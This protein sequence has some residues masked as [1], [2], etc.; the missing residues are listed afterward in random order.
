MTG[1]A[2]DRNNIANGIL[3]GIVLGCG[4][5]FSALAAVIIKKIISLE[6]LPSDE[7]S[8]TT[9]STLPVWAL[10]FAYIVPGLMGLVATFVK[11]KGMYITH[12]VFSIITLLAMGI[13]FVLGIISIAALAELNVNVPQC[14]P[15]DTG[16]DIPSSLYSMCISVIVFIILG[17][18]FTLVT[19]ILSGILACRNENNAHLV[20]MQNVPPSMTTVAVTSAASCYSNPN[21]P[22]KY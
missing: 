16:C 8:L 1:I 13:F 19:T 10:G 21:Y 9:L 4:I 20:Y 2:G 11:A 17:W 18:I 12:M 15:P 7:G 5:V 14:I 3:S 6:N 22:T